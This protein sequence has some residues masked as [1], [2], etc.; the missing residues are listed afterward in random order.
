[1]PRAEPKTVL[2]PSEAPTLVE[3]KPAATATAPARADERRLV[4]MTAALLAAAAAVV[5][6]LIVRQLVRP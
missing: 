1:M 3:R 2:D 5:A 4:V 6:V